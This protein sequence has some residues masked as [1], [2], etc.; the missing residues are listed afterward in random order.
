MKF[1]I[2]GAEGF[3]RVYVPFITPWVVDI[4]TNT[5]ASA[6]PCEL[7]CSIR[8]V[9]GEAC[10]LDGWVWNHCRHPGFCE[11]N[12]TAVP[13]FSLVWDARPQFT[14]FVIQWLASKIVG[15]GGRKA[16]RLSL[17]RTP[18]LF[19]LFRRRR[20]F[21]DC[22]TQTKGSDAVSVNNPPAFKNSKSGLRCAM[23]EPM[24]KSVSLS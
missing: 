14:E 21:L 18:A 11:A 15:R 8:A 17:M 13:C 2:R 7:L 24:F 1:Q 12:N 3:N 20:R 9:H 16:R 19:P 6:F 5:S 22:T 10:E 4:E 23:E